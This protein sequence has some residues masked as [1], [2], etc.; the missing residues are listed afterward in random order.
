MKPM[1]KQSEE[2]RVIP[3]YLNLF[4]TSTAAMKGKILKDEVVAWAPFLCV[5]SKGFADASAEPRYDKIAEAGGYQP[6]VQLCAPSNV[7]CSRLL[8][9]VSSQV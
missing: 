6:L 8:R 7:S 2:S 5:R 4:S 3:L 9:A 1:S